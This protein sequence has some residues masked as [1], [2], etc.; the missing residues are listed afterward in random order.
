LSMFPSNY[1]TL[2]F[3]LWNTEAT[4]ECILGFSLLDIVLVNCKAF[5]R[6]NWEPI[7]IDVV[8]RN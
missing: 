2:H 4:F 7:Q 5:E 6:N 8:V 1:W 3:A